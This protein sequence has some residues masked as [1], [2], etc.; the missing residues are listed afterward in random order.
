M[1][2]GASVLQLPA[3]IKAREM[4][5]EVIA[6]DMDRNAIGF[7]YADICLEISTIDTT[8]VIKAAQYYNIN[9]ILTVASDIPMKTVA[10]VA[11]KLN[12]VGISE[13]TALKTTNKILM[14]ESLKKY[15]VPIP[16][17]RKV[18]SSAE[19]MSVIKKV[20]EKYIVKPADNSGS[21]GV[22]L[23][24]DNKNTSELK[25]AYEYSR[26]YA[27]DGDVII[28][29][30]MR[31]PEVSVE[32]ISIEGEVN[33][34][35]ITDKITTGP[36]NFVEVAHSQ[37]TMLSELLRREI[38][39]IT[40]NAVKAVGI[41]NGPSHTEIILTDE[42]PKIV[43]LGARM[44]GDNITTHLVPLSTGID[45]VKCC[46]EIALGEKPVFTKSIN[47]GAAI[48]YIDTRAGK[49]TK[50]SGVDVASSLSGVKQVSIVKNIGEYV[51]EIKSSTDRVG[52][53]IAQSDDAKS[54]IKS[55]Q[56]AISSI[57][58]DVDADS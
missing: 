54:A 58:I 28:E 24:E 3:I 27:R 17:F 4:G 36:P 56:N 40:I 22:F 25:Y 57:T 30:Y 8:E 19:Y 23:L 5:L 26:K 2:L 55:C 9:G 12:I 13:D 48:Q 32:S 46:I 47:R 7:E 41:E 14:R 52:F 15:N 42:G 21:R 11:N 51:G 18:S 33:I 49:I 10:A 38:E 50:I 6:V 39:I 1:I 45:M 16:K 20:T 43:E 44:G 29:E 37:P 35:A 53:V 34:L 31:G